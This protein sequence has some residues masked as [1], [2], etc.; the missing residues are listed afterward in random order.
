M[1]SGSRLIAG[2]RRRYWICTLS[3]ETPGGVATKTLGL[4]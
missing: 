1:S 3:K 2:E 4:K